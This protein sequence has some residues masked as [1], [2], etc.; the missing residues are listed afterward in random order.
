VDRDRRR[1]AER[2]A[3]E[4]MHVVIADLDDRQSVLPTALTRAVVPR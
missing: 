2:L 3:A 4:G 1:V